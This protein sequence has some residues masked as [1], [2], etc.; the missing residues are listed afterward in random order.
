VSFTVWRCQ[1]A[2]ASRWKSFGDRRIAVAS[3]SGRRDGECPCRCAC[4]TVV[5][6]S[7][8]AD[9][10]ARG[11]D[12][13]CTQEYAIGEQ[14]PG[15]AANLLNRRRH[16]GAGRV[17]Q[18]E[19]AAVDADDRFGKRQLGDDIRGDVAGARSRIRD[20]HTGRGAH[21]F[22]LDT[23]HPVAHFHRHGWR[24]LDDGRFDR[25][26]T[27]IASSSEHTR[28]QEKVDVGIGKVAEELLR[29]DGFERLVIHRRGYRDGADGARRDHHR[30]SVE[31]DR[32]SLVGQRPQTRIAQE[33]VVEEIAVAVEIAKD[34]DRERIAAVDHHAAR[35]DRSPF[36]F[37]T[38][39]RGAA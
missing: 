16:A 1:R 39:F 9:R 25:R 31:G 38:R 18:R 35:I 6:V 2:A 33:R 5:S 7:A 13:S 30:I 36:A 32:G 4:R 12:F 21:S 20:D 28:L 29:D 17:E 15:A 19:C 14:S 23:D 10:D 8:H 27:A 11:I 34:R 26:A 37:V 22:A 3:S 24:A